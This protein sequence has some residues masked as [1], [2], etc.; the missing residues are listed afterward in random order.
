[1]WAYLIGHALVA[2][3]HHALGDDIF[4]RMFWVKR[5][6]THATVPAE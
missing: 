4:S 1:M 6:R 5:R 2:L 3:V